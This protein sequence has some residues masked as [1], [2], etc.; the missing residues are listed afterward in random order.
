MIITLNKL[1]SLK[2][3]YTKINDNTLRAV[4]VK[5]R[6]LLK[7]S[8]RGCSKLSSSSVRLPGDRQLGL[9]DLD[10]REIDM[11]V[12][13]SEVRLK[14][15]HLLRLNNRCTPRGTE[16]LKVHSTNFL[17]RVGARLRTGT[18]S[19]KRKRMGTS[20]AAANVSSETI[21]DNNSNC[22]GSTDKC[23][24]LRT[25][26]VGSKDTHQEMFV[27][28]TCFGNGFQRFVCLP[29]ARKCHQDEGHEVFSVGYSQGYCD[30]CIFSPC[31]CLA[32]RGYDED[33]IA[34]ISIDIPGL[35]GVLE[36]PF[37]P[38][39]LSSARRA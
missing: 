16:M 12:P 31:K 11:D 19:K 1:R 28:K 24:I 21:V 4:L 39:V 7:L 38:S 34:D 15:P 22:E 20:E 25:G 6:Q 17:W 30:C 18:K 26:F 8:V 32:N 2:L 10:C 23:T 9:V 13:L 29:C 27:C 3:D 33:T 37:D 5:S 35:E 36:V 14:C